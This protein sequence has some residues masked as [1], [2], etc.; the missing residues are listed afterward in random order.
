MS[1]KL[2]VN[3]TWY[4]ADPT[5]MQNLQDGTTLT[6]A[7]TDKLFDFKTEGTFGADLIA[8]T[9]ALAGLYSCANATNCT[10]AEI[11]GLQWGSAGVT[12]NPLYKNDDDYLKTASSVK[13]WWSTEWPAID[14]APEYYSYAS[15][16]SGS[17]ATAPALPAT[18]VA[19]IVSNS[20]EDLGLNNYYN[21]GRLVNAFAADDKTK[22]DIFTKAIG[23][24]AKVFAEVMRYHI[25]TY[26]MGGALK[27]YTAEQLMN[28]YENDIAAKINGG[29]YYG[30]YDFSICNDTT[31]VF[32]D[33]LG[34]V[35]EATYGIYT[36]S[37]GVDEIAEVRTVNGEAF[38]NRIQNVWN[39]TYFT[40]VP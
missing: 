7:E 2:F 20:T 25:Q 11:G 36:G 12:L 19:V 24:D 16:V 13:D 21:T 34:S 22:L 28:G 38:V 5:Y 31:P 40:A 17:D 33:M 27:T 4:Y 26:T 3:A 30:G 32:N 10:G 35:S 18:A 14:Q 23:Y 1:L 6:S 37:N 29:Q 39:G 15:S 9:T 8:Q